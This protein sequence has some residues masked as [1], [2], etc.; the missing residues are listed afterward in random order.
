MM[1]KE[2]GMFLKK[3]GPSVEDASGLVKAPKAKENLQ[4]RG[5]RSN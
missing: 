5:G 1:W 3:E 2:V 4:K